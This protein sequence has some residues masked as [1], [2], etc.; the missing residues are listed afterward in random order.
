M[1]VY[2]CVLVGIQVCLC[3][4]L[5]EINLRYCFLGDIHLVFL[6]KFLIG[7]KFTE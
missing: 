3:M 2:V 7:L 4:W 6:D 5:P 1:S